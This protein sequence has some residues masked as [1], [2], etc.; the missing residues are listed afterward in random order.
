[1]RRRRSLPAPS[2]T[3]LPSSPKGDSTAW[4]LALAT[5]LLWSTVATAFKLGLRTLTPAELLAGANAV[6]A[7]TLSAGLVLTGRWRALLG[8]SR[9]DHGRA[10]LLAVLNPWLYYL[11]L[12]EAYDRL[13]AQVAQALN[14]TWALT[15]TLLAVPVLGHR[16]RALELGAMSIAWLGAAIIAT[17]GSTTGLSV[18]DPLGVGLAFFSTVLW[19]SYWLLAA[20]ATTPP[21]ETLA[22]AFLYALPLTLGTALLTGGSWPTGYSAWGAILWVGLAE[23]AISFVLWLLALQRA[24]STAGIASLIFLAPFLSLLWLEHLLGEAL[25]PATPVGLAVIV[26]GL[27]LRQR[28]SSLKT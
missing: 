21:V 28:V 26:L 17:G 16:L 9:Q 12:F 22:V 7:G 19:A 10:L 11:I 8:F 13:P 1:M 27:L 15:L 14:Y 6:A 23:M 5:V 25:R 20:R 24:G 18:D 2:A 3:S 4:G